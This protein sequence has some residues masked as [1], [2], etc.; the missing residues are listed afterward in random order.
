MHH[1]RYARYL[2][3]QTDKQSDSA[4]G[5]IKEREINKTGGVHR[6]QKRFR[7]RHTH[8]EADLHAGKKIFLENDCKKPYQST[9]PSARRESTLQNT[10]TMRHISGRAGG[11]GERRVS[12]LPCER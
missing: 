10:C 12:K 5:R 1:C 11:Q 7:E 3:T 9:K 8:T 6:Q 4:G 2:H